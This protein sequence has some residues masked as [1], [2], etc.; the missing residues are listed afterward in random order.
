MRM[1]L[2]KVWQHAYPTGVFSRQMNN[3]VDIQEFGS[4]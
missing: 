4:H 1:F 2:D 3:A